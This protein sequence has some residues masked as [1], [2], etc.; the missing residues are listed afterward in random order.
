[1]AR[2]NGQLDVITPWS[3]LIADALAGQIKVKDVSAFNKHAPAFLTLMQAVAKKALA[4]M[5]DAEVE[6]V[7][8]VC[9][10]GFPGA[11]APKITKVAAIYR[12]ESI[13]VLD[14]HV[15]RAFGFRPEHFSLKS[16]TRVADIGAVLVALRDGLRNHEVAIRNLRDEVRNDVPQLDEVTDLSLIDIVLWTSQDD[17]FDRKGKAANSWLNASIGD[18][19]T[20]S[21]VNWLSLK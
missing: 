14:G 15:G 16:K 9:R 2:Q 19:L 6:A 8:D 1:M 10:F 11:W 20:T 13:P 21:S 3:M 18:A 12:P 5:D 7:A 4:E 17:R